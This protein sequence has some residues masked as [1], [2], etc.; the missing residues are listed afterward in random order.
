MRKN[1]KNNNVIK[2]SVTVV[3]ILL[4]AIT[5]I[6]LEFNIYVPEK[7]LEVTQ[8]EGTNRIIV[9]VSKGFSST[10]TGY[11]FDGKFSNISIAIII[12][13]EYYKGKYNIFKTE[14]TNEIPLN[15]LPIKMRSD[16]IKCW[17][18]ESNEEPITKWAYED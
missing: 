8:E 6:N 10:E 5:I 9:K 16:G 2:I 1:N 3:M 12:Q 4:V 15:Y 18:L 7:T 17:R 11:T 14:S 13:N